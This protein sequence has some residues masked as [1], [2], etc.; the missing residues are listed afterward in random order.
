MYRAVLCR[1]TFNATISAYPS[2]PPRSVVTDLFNPNPCALTRRGEDI[3]FIY[4]F[5]IYYFI[6]QIDSSGK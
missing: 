1:V 2:V 5:S 6:I 4:M 3:Q